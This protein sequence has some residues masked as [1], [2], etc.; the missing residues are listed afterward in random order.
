MSHFSEDDF[1]ARLFAPMAAPQGFGLRDDAAVLTPPEGHDLVLTKDALVAG[2]HFFADDRPADIARKLLRVNLSDLAAKGAEPLGFLLAL[3]IPSSCDQEFWQAFAAGLG[4]D[5]ARFSCPLFG[6]DTVR[7]SGPLVMTLTALGVVPHGH[8]V[9]RFGARVGDV[10]YVSGTI[11]DAALGL[12]V[13]RGAQWVRDCSD[14]ARQFLRDRYLLPQPRVALRRA[15]RAEAQGSMDI[16][17]GL[18]GDAQ[19]MMRVSGV[20][21]RIDLARVP[22]SPACAEALERHPHLFEQIF[23]GGD[24]YEILASVPPSR[25]RAFEAEAI[26]AGVRVTAIGHVVAGEGPVEFTD[27][28]GALCHFTRASYSHF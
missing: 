4:E 21:A 9:A 23:T 26:D 20:S 17:D 12:D 10:L 6:G 19:K 3:A 27:R 7:S 25:A 22:L 14:E 8:H 18:V 5:S 24:D 16:S 15:V 28:H 11:G 2:V 1:I 13:R